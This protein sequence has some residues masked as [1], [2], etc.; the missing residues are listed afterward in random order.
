MNL[1]KSADV[2]GAANAGW[3]FNQ[4]LLEMPAEWRSIFFVL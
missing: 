1:L 4:N 2:A 3:L